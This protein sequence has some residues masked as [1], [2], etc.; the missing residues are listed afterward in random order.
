MNAWMNT[1]NTVS[2]TNI[3]DI[4]ANS[5]KLIDVDENGDQTLTNIIDLFLSYSAISTVIDVNIPIGGGLF[6][7]VKQWVG[8]VDDKHVPGLQSLIAYMDASYRRI[9]DDSIVNNYYNTIHKHKNLQKTDT[10]NYN[11]IIKNTIVKKHDYVNRY[12]TFSYNKK[13]SNKNTVFRVVPNYIQQDIHFTYVKQNNQTLLNMI[14]NLQSQ[15]DN[16]QTQINNL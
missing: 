9:D 8:D 10:F 5:I 6:Y 1:R 4:A 16:L 2:L 12:D 7:T 15:I 3:I 13:I 14:S 11:K